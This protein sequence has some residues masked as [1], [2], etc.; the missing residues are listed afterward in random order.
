M[1]DRALALS[2]L[3]ACVAGAVL[4][5]AASANFPGQNGRIVFG[6][7]EYDR[8]ASFFS[9]TPGALYT[10]FA[11]GSG[12]T[13]LADDPDYNDFEAAWSP[14]GQRLAYASLYGDGKYDGIY[15]GTP[16][17]ETPKLIAKGVQVDTPAW[18]PDGGTVMYTDG[19]KG[20]M[21][22]PADGSAAPRV[23]VKRVKGWQMVGATFSA[24]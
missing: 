22:V 3:A 8:K 4:P 12:A 9:L 15:V 2:T 13:A 24:D 20:L 11:D 7:H 18:S 23:I 19:T 5:A 14:D 16:D 21:A 10:V 17:A 6:V 1:S